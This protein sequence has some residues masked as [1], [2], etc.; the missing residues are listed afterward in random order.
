[1]NCKIQLCNSQGQ[2]R[3]DLIHLLPLS[4]LQDCATGQG[5]QS[6][7]W[8]TPEGKGKVQTNREIIPDIVRLGTFHPGHHLL[9]DKGC[10]LPNVG[11]SPQLFVGLYA[12]LHPSK[13]NQL[14]RIDY[15]HISCSRSWWTFALHPQNCFERMPLLSKDAPAW[16]NSSAVN[17]WSPVDLIHW[18]LP[19]GKGSWNVVSGGRKSD[20]R[21]SL[22]SYSL[23]T[24]YH[25][26]CLLVVSNTYISEGI[27]FRGWISPLWGAWMRQGWS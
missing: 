11:L 21:Q 14:C 20:F 27:L 17:W 24:L 19:N 12:L 16:A 22:F 10:C 9:W 23:A 7:K 18:L 5:K 2:T 13:K 6:Q 8:Y 26:K 1:M 25:G 4:F 3:C 15:N